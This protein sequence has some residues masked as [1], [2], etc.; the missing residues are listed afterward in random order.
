VKTEVANV[1]QTMVHQ[2]LKAAGVEKLRTV[3]Q[4]Q[5]D[6]FMKRFYAIQCKGP[7]ALPG[8]ILGGHVRHI[9]NSRPY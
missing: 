1:N 3:F 8:P 2:K 7:G 6:K 5:V 9:A 4:T